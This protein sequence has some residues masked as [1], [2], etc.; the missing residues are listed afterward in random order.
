M[1]ICLFACLK[2]T[3]FMKDGQKFQVRK[4]KPLHRNLQAAFF[5]TTGGANP[6]FENRYIGM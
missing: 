5:L 6:L 1:Q 2:Q 4:V 3:L